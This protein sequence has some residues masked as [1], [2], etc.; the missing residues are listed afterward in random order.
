[1]KRVAVLG[2]VL[3]AAAVTAAAHGARSPKAELAAMRRAVAGEHSAHYVWLGTGP[4]GTLR[5]VAD[6][7]A[8]EATSMVTTTGPKG[9]TTRWRSIVTKRSGYLRGDALTLHREFFLSKER[10]ARYAGKWI[11]IPPESDP[12]AELGETFHDFVGTLFPQRKL[13][14][15][16]A[17]KLVGVRGTSRYA[18]A[19]AV[20]TIL[21]PTH[22]KALPSRQTI[23]YPGHPA[24]KGLEKISR[25]NK[26]LHITA[27]AHPL[28]YCKVFGC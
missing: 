17:G 22:G 26:P 13:S 20:V 23:R 19:G 27:P 9:R 4:G 25:W 5:K 28:P 15:V 21:A 24:N 2:V 16:A 18:G 6:V 11:V 1:V 12:Y 10:A 7:G 8:G 14:L 3:A